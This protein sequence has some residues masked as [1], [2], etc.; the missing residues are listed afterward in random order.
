MMKEKANYNKR[1]LRV[2]T[3][4][5]C[6]IIATLS[7]GITASAADNRYTFQTD[8]SGSGEDWTLGTEKKEYSSIT[9]SC[10]SSSVKA[11]MQLW[12]KGFWGNYTRYEQDQTISVGYNRRVWWFGDQNNSGKYHVTANVSNNYGNTVSFTGYFQN[13]S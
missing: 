6:V 13:F 5:M 2:I 1:T 3:L 11:T 9:V 12:K 10:Q 8:Y 7:L 4:I